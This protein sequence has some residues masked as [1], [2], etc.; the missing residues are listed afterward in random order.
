MIQRVVVIGAYFIVLF[1]D[2]VHMKQGNQVF[3]VASYWV[4]SGW[5]AVGF[6]VGGELFLEELSSSPPNF[7]DGSLRAASSSWKSSPPRSS[8][9]QFFFGGLYWYA[10]PQ[11]RPFVFPSLSTPALSSVVLAPVS[12]TIWGGRALPGRALHPRVGLGSP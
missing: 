4:G 2:Q 11:S 7:L 8:G 5:R 9:S 3:S 12:F 1:I 10:S 6:R